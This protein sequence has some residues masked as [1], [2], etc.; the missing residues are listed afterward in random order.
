[1]RVVIDYQKIKTKEKTEIPYFLQNFLSYHLADK[2]Y[3]EDIDA[4]S[5]D[6]IKNSKP[7]KKFKR[8]ICYGHTIEIEIEQ[9][10]DYKDEISVEEFEKV[11][12]VFKDAL[13]HLDEVKF[14]YDFDKKSL[15]QD[16]ENLV[17]ILPKDKEGLTFWVKED[18]QLKINDKIF[19]YRNNNPNFDI[20]Q[21]SKNIPLREFDLNFADP[22][23]L[24]REEKKEQEN[25]NEGSPIVWIQ[26]EFITRYIRKEIRKL[27]FTGQYNRVVVILS[28]KYKIQKFSEGIFILVPFDQ[29]EYKK[30]YP[31]KILSRLKKIIPNDNELEVNH[32]ISDLLVDALQYAKTQNVFLPLDEMIEIINNF[33]A[34]DYKF[35]W[36]HKSRVFKALKV[37]ARL[38]CKLFNNRFELDFVLLKEK[39][40]VFRKQIHKSQPWYEAWRHYYED[41]ILEDGYLVV[42]QQYGGKPIFKLS[43]DDIKK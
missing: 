35:E 31:H 43:I 23:Y 39:K 4:I 20:R 32:F 36:Y 9:N 41:V 14:K 27:K 2:Y 12:Y 28:N 42:S 38:H 3:G 11:F 13:I 6:F 25:A 18:I 16:V 15:I 29:E 40:E 5:I 10:F 7:N 8:R 37:K 30:I 17:K 24:T 21:Q 33:R 22:T 19:E 34:N 26:S 1:M